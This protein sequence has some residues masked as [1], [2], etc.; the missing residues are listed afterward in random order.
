MMLEKLGRHADLLD[1]FIAKRDATAVVRTCRRY[2]DAAPHVWER[3]LDFLVANAPTQV[4]DAPSKSGANLT[5]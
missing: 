5:R 3:A 2:A 4:R 1:H